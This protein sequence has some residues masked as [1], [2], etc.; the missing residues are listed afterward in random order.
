MPSLD[1]ESIE[2]NHKTLIREYVLKSRPQLKKDRTEAQENAHK[3][4]LLE[5]K[6]PNL[7][8]AKMVA[9]T[10]LW[11]DNDENKDGKLT[12]AE[13]TKC[14]N[15]YMKAQDK[16]YGGETTLPDELHEENYNLIL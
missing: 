13:F 16:K 12:C 7:V 4:S 2:E 3:A 5:W 14:M 9:I 6:D 1:M 11:M 10:E 15:D 8:T